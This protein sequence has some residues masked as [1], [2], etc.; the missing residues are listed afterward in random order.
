MYRGIPS[1]LRYSPE[2]SH[3]L[4]GVMLPRSLQ[5]VYGISNGRPTLNY[6]EEALTLTIYECILRFRSKNELFY[7]DL[8]FVDINSAQRHNVATSQRS[9]IEQERGENLTL[10]QSTFCRPGGVQIKI[11]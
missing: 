10:G 3:H 11:V 9:N 6:T 2:Q 7:L 4:P 5:V 1:D 8:T